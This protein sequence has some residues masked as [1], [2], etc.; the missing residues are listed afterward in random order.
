MPNLFP[1]N[2]SGGVLEEVKVSKQTVF[3]R[4]WRFDFETGEFMVTP[5]GKVVTADE[6]QAWVEWCQKAL[7][8]E[9][10]RYL[11]YSRSYGQEFDDLIALHL[12]R[13]ANEMELK[14]MTKEAL[15][16]D[17]RTAKAE[18]VSLQWEGD[19][20]FFMCEVTSRRGTSVQMNMRMVP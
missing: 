2:E 9:R 8:T 13:E 1:V 5:A 17:P 20:C 16:A 12:T 4:S 14:R 18:M 11:A 19:H 6:D 3:G 10:Y 15:M 7:H